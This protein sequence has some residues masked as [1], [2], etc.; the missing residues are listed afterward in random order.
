MASFAIEIADTDVEKVITALCGMYGYTE[1][2]G[3]TPNQY[4]N[5]VVRNFI[6]EVT[7]AYAVKQAETTLQAARESVADISV[8]DPAS[9]EVA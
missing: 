2:S 4:A 1:E 3:L 6:K 7:I 8:S 9:P 5:K